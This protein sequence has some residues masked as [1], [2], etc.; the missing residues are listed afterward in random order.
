MLPINLTAVSVAALAAFVLGFLF[1]GP[2]S[3]KLWMKLANVHP[4]GNEKFADMIPQLL[5][6]L[7]SQFVTAF[8]LAGV[9]WIAF[10]SPLM[11]PVTWYKGAICGAWI[12]LGFLITSSST[13][14]IWMGRTMKLWL[15]EA[16]CSLIVMGVMG[17]IIAG[18]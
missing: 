14:V 8:V 3:G 18:W 13:E 16:V 17:A 11:G 10:S 7:L 9:L 6:T 15:F 12:W 2:V 5:W 1:H 4:T